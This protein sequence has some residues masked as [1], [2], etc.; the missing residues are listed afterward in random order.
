MQQLSTTKPVVPYMFIEVNLEDHVMP[1]FPP[2]QPL[3]PHWC[4]FG[5]SVLLIYLQTHVLV[6]LI[7]LNRC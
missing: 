2:V 7:V 4:I 3:F 5:S 6:T 1:V